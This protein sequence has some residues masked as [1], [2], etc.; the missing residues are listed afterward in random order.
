MFI[1][2]KEN[3]EMGV[4]YEDWP[5][6]KVPKVISVLTS[7][8]FPC[9]R[10]DDVSPLMCCPLSIW[11]HSLDQKEEGRYQGCARTKSFL[12]DGLYSSGLL[13]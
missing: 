4:K 13:P 8:I 2:G 5:H 9:A 6:Q 12:E 11:I 3:T 7:S 1:V 10:Q